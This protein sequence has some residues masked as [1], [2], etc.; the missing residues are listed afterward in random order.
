MAEREI[1]RGV[2]PAQAADRQ[3]LVRDVLLTDGSTLRLRAATPDDHEDIVAFYDG[4]SPESRYLRFHGF[5]RTDLAA[6]ALIEASGED[7][8]GLIGHQGGRIVAAAQYDVLREPG[9]A[10][11]AFAVADDFRRRGTA[12]RML[13]QLAQIG[14]E[15]GLGRFDAE[16]LTS[17]RPM[18]RVFGQAG[19]DVRRQGAFGEVTVSLDITA[20]EGA[21]DRIDARDHLAAVASLR[22]MLAPDSVVVLGGASELGR[23]VL[24]NIEAGGFQGEVASGLDELEGTPDLVIVAGEA[25]EWTEQAAAAVAAGARAL[26][27]VSSDL[28][29]DA[30]RREQELL[31]TVRA[32]GLRLLGP[33]SL[34]VINTDPRVGLHAVSS[35]TSIVPGRLSIG[36]QSGAI[37]IGLLGQA[38]ARRLGV[39][40]YVSLGQR[41]DVSTND[42]LELW[43]EDPRTSAVMLYMEA[44]A[45]PEHFA[46]IASRVS[47]RKPILVVKGRRAAEVVRLE[48]HTHTAAALRG[49][50]VVDALFHQAGMLRFRGGEE[51]F[52]AARFFESQPLP[53]GR[54]VAIVSNSAGVATL[55]LDACITRGLVVSGEG[56]PDVLGPGAGPEDYART[57]RAML[58]DPAADALL[59][60]YVERSGADAEDVLAA[61]SEASTEHD[62]PVVASIIG[63]DGQTAE[64]SGGQIPNLVFPEA[65]AAV[66]ARAVER[67]EWLSRPLGERPRLDG[68]DPEAAR[69][70]LDRCLERGSEWLELAQGEELLAT[71]GIPCE[72]AVWCRSL[73]QAVSEAAAVG[74]PVALKAACRPPES[75]ADYDAVLLGLEGEEAIR[76]GW[77]ELERRSELG[78]REWIGAIVQRL[79]EP[80]TDV[81]VGAVRDPDLG[82]VM[83]VGLGGRHAGLAGS[84]AFRVLPGTDVEADELIDASDGLVARMEGF[85]GHPRLHRDALRDLV[86]RFSAL[87]RA[88]PEAVEVDLNPVRLTPERCVV[89]EMRIRAERRPPPQRVKTW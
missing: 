36:S 67:R 86:L 37:G 73:E 43:E 9:V 81:L 76:A 41:V 53:R 51:L 50:A 63:S 87:L 16:V 27:V 39:A 22:P 80:G 38:A 61:V 57:A 40:S 59:V 20:S 26:L 89:L 70:H 29:P 44:F 10:E 47:R 65:C 82:P 4:L 83:A 34:G 77:H 68:L 45:N 74:A 58:A 60:F 72:P 56:N 1:E 12:T 14:A 18:L 78:E 6:K 32:G 48:A 64:G 21:R 8:V 42:L 11:V 62:K 19:F 24:A 79:V 66:L 55:A 31:E 88:C 13:E 85:R 30:E 71:H 75:P 35:A 7:R 46:R 69:T 84:C 33:S 54:Q 49:D 2:T 52:N 15:H 3:R 23:V 25:V 28:A 5:G 17:N